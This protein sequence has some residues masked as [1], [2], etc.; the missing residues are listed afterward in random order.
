MDDTHKFTKSD[1]SCQFCDETHKASKEWSDFTP[2]TNLQQRM[3][4]VVRRIERRVSIKKA[5]SREEAFS[6]D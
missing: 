3:V 4:D 2:E 1:C 6:D 5:F